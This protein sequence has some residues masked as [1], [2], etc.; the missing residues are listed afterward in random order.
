MVVVFGYEVQAIGE[1]HG[2]L[3][4][5]EAERATLINKR[6]ADCDSGDSIYRPVRISPNVSKPN[7]RI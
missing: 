3:Q 6:S 4:A 2:L 7:S 5:N 1:V